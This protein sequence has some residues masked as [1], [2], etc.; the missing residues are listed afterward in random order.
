MFSILY[1]VSPREQDAISVACSYEFHINKPKDFTLEE[2]IR[3]QGEL[4]FTTIKGREPWSRVV[5]F[6]H[7]LNKDKIVIAVI[8]KDALAQV[9]NRTVY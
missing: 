9:L 1:N 2:A 4:G 8:H 3:P 6:E 5:A 7:N